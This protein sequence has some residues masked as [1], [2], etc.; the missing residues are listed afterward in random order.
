MAG[1]VAV[2]VQCP[3]CW[4]AIEMLVDTSVEEQE[5]V[6]DCHVCCR[7]LLVTVAVPFGSEAPQV[8]VRPEN[9]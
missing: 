5:Y 1:L 4:E 6:E 7:P 9:D 3:H 2:T 8:A